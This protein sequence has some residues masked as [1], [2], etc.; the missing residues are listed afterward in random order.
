MRFTSVSPN[1]SKVVKFLKEEPQKSRKRTE[2]DLN[3]SPSIRGGEK[4]GRPVVVRE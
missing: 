3:P 4:S 1:E 2:P